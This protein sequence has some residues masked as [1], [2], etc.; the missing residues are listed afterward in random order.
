MLAEKSQEARTATSAWHATRL[1]A[2]SPDLAAAC[3]DHKPL[4]EGYPASHGPQANCSVDKVLQFQAELADSATSPYE[5]LAAV[6]FLLNLVGDLN[7]P[8]LAIDH[9]DRGGQCIAVQVGAHP[10]V[11]LAD[12]LAGNAGA[13]GGGRECRPRR[14]A[15]IAAAVPAGDAQKWAE[16]NPEAWARD[17]LRDRQDRCL[18]LRRREARGQRR[19]AG[20][21]GRDASLRRRAGLQGRADYETKALAAVRTQLAKAGVR[22]AQVL[23]AGFR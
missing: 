16:G 23:R 10:P 21:Q 14:A 3:F 19:S 9:G 8:L 1:K 18:R 4:P 13:R 5:R 22:L 11:R 12:L 20:A 7:D 2:D 17:S 15:R 6:E